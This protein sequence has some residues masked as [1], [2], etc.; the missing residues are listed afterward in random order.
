MKISPL[1]P[2]RLPAMGARRL[3][4][5]LVVSASVVAAGL[6]V[7]AAARATPPGLDEAGPRIDPA[8]LAS[9]DGDDPVVCTF[10]G[11]APGDYDVTVELGSATAASTEVFAESRR[12]VLSAVDTEAGEVQRRSFTVNV[13]D[14]EGQ[15]NQPAGTGDPG[16][17]LTFAGSAPA[18]TGIGVAPALPRTRQVVLIGDSTVTD[19][20]TWPYAGW[21]QRL[22]AHVGLGA[23]VVNHSGSGESTVSVL[24]KPEMFDAVEPQLDVGD[25]ALIQLAHNDKTTTAAQ[26]RA[27]L[28]EL[29]DRVRARGATPVLVTPIVRLRFTNGVIN[30]VGLIVTDLADLPAEMRG[31][32]DQLGVPLI[33]LTERSRA[34]VESLGPVASEPI[35]LIRVN[36]DRTHTSEYGAGVYA[37]IV[38]E[39]LRTLGLLPPHLW[40]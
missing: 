6:A 40:R 29:V 35:Y 7:P 25:V 36:G 24:A 26:Y 38:A 28:T 27:N 15:Q 32:A 16:L 21:G 23:S 8:L 19:Q 31:V 39:E 2:L 18:V 34:L 11:L 13:R 22:P 37:G 9:C 14:P 10:E 17:T 1:F 20:E 4:A 3:A 12:L 5:P 30:P 33:D